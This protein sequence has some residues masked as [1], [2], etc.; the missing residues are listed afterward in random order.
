MFTNNSLCLYLT[1]WLTEN[2]LPWEI[3]DAESLHE[4][5]KQPDKF[6]EEKFV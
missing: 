1:T 2:S 4:F 3:M 5:K 6:L